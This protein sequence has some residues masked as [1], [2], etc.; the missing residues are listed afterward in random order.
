M[1]NKAENSNVFGNS[2]DLHRTGKVM[3]EAKDKTLL[4]M[5]NHFHLKKYNS[6]IQSLGQHIKINYLDR[7]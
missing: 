5:E 2:L 4:K 3:S 6:M 7:K 1:L